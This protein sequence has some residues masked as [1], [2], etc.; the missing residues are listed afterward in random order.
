MNSNA[1]RWLFDKGL[2]CVLLSSIIQS[3]RGQG[4]MPHVV[5][6][7]N[8]NLGHVPKHAGEQKTNT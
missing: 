2:R 7:S 6:Y 8:E 1:W 5:I 4:V 3:D